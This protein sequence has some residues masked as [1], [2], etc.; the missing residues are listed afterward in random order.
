[1]TLLT[2][3]A[4][5]LDPERAHTLSIAALA[6]AD[7][8]RLLRAAPSDKRLAR[9]V[10]GLDF[11]NPIGLAAGFDK[12]AV[13]PA[14]YA[15]L[16]FGFVEI[17]TVTPRPQPG[18][19]RPRLFR[20]PADRAVINRMGFN[21]NGIDACVA[22]L[23]HLR[24]AGRLT[25][26]LGLN[27]G[28]NREG[29]DPERDYPA[30]VEAA[31]RVADYVVI[32]ISSPNTPGLRDLQTEQR[33]DAI[34]T[35]IAPRIP[36]GARLLVKLA[37]DLADDAIRTLV[38]V[39]AGSCASGLIVTNT[40]IARPPTLKDPNNHQAGGLSGPPLA[41][42]ALKIL[43]LAVTARAGDPL[44][45]IACGGITNAPDIQRRLDAG[46]D[47]V[48]LYTALA[49]EGPSLLPRLARELLAGER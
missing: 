40:T 18:N 19:P 16:G 49:Y 14:A 29:A 42:R 13:A 15:A 3:L 26:P 6:A 30:L 39:I 31:A 12:D 27:V 21:N 7:R 45:I 28:I 11:P 32:N 2:S 24:D 5:R 37:P 48:Q 43:D 46:A 34:L 23:R 25:V 41:P 9:T 33:L 47:L 4:H 38:R 1:M 17:G 44:V 20:L 35:A 10:M 36:A 22:R 8:L